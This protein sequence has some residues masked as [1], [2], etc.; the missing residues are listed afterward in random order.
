MLSI[1]GFTTTNL[2]GYNSFENNYSTIVFDE[3]VD[4]ITG[5]LVSYRTTSVR[6]P[7]FCTLGEY[8]V[9]VLGRQKKGQTILLTIIHWQ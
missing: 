9:E 7:G 4:F 1:V 8:F 5:D 3:E 2:E 6:N